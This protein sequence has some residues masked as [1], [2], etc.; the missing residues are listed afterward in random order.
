LPHE[1]HG[2]GLGQA[3][4]SEIRAGVHR[5]LGEIEQENAARALLP[6]DAHRFLRHGLMGEEIQLEALAQ[7]LV[8]D[9]A[10]PA[11]P[12]GAGIGHENIDP[13]EML[14][15]RGENRFDL[16]GLGHVALQPEALDGGGCLLRLL[17]VDIDNPDS[18]AFGG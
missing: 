1:Q 9:I 4:G 16:I 12:R 14:R 6:H 18:G 15:E 2:G 13:A 17:A 11:L 10:D 5:L 7:G 8:G 3:V